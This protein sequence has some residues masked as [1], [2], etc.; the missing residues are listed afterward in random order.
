[1]A[2]LGILV[3]HFMVRPKDRI[4]CLL[5]LHLLDS[6]LYQEFFPL[7]FSFDQNFASPAYPPATL[8]P[9]ISTASPNVSGRRT[10][11]V[12]FVLVKF[13]AQ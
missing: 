9:S 8:L 1:M 10:G 11:S 4:D 12:T 3:L 13:E 7:V 5:Y 6:D 2:T